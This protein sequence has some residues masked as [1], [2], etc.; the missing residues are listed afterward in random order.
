MSLGDGFLFV[1]AD[2]SK[3]FWDWRVSHFVD[4]LAEVDIQDSSQ[5]MT[6]H[7]ISPCHAVD[8]WIKLKAKILV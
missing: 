6:S 1:Q 8:L 2:L 3:G 5:I 7:N 4:Q